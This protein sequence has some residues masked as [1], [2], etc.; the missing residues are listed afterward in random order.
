MKRL[1]LYLALSLLALHSHPSVEAAPPVSVRDFRPIAAQSVRLSVS[2]GARISGPSSGSTSKGWGAFDRGN[3][4]KAMDAF[5]SALEANPADASAAEGLTM[6]VYR[7]GDRISAA[8]LGEEFFPAMPWIREVVVETLIVEIR[9]EIE[10]GKVHE[11]K[12]LAANLPYAGGAY[13]EVRLLAESQGEP[14]DVRRVDLGGTANSPSGTKGLVKVSFPQ[15][16]SRPE[17]EAPVELTSLASAPLRA[18]PV[19]GSGTN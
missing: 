17:E 2:D 9:R 7:S 18:E 3:W 12:E 14:G 11:V 4:E 6:S 13:E 5:L 1:P 10:E 8:Q 16:A 15:N 19:P